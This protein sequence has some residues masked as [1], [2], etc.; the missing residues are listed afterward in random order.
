MAGAAMPVTATDVR[1]TLDEVSHLV[2]ES[3]KARRADP[4]RCNATL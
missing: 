1:F 3:F 4:G 2:D